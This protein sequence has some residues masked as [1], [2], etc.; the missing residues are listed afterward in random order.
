MIV[1]IP[2]L[3]FGPWIAENLQRFNRFNKPVDSVYPQKNLQTEG[4]HSQRYRKHASFK[5]TP[6]ESLSPIQR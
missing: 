5:R 3:K 6:F 1:A 4:R 2:G